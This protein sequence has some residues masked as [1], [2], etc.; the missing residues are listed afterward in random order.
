[1]ENTSKNVARGINRPT[2]RNTPVKSVPPRVKNQFI[3]ANCGPTPVRK[4]HDCLGQTLSRGDTW[5][6][7]L[8]RKTDVMRDEAP[9]HSERSSVLSIST[10][11]TMNNANRLTFTTCDPMHG[12]KFIVREF[13]QRLKALHPDDEV[14]Y[15]MISEIGHLVKR[16]EYGDVLA[17]T[18]EEVSSKRRVE[19]CVECE[20][21]SSVLKQMEED[22]ACEK[23]QNKVL[24]GRIVDLESK[25]AVKEN[26]LVQLEQELSQVTEQMKDLQANF[27]ERKLYDESLLNKFDEY[28][29][30]LQEVT[31]ELFVTKLENEKLLMQ[32]RMKMLVI[33]NLQKKLDKIDVINSALL[34]S[35]EARKKGEKA[36]LEIDRKS[37]TDL[38]Y[39]SN[40]SSMRLLMFENATVPTI[41]IYKSNH[42][43]NIL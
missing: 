4:I 22:L 11:T 23:E 36:T 37:S 29:K 12:I 18:P 34:E 19:K 1:M 30:K 7:S 42:M 20:G 27:V 33:E 6:N 9:F 41:D 25:I 35:T 17:V 8:Q 5:H 43:S 16:L 24:S 15:Q 40:D 14:F 32:L 13:K 3:R 21:L 31:Q 38:S 39:I 10:M 28:N 2:T 26:N